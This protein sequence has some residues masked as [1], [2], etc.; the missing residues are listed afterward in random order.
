[1]EQRKP[2]LTLWLFC[3]CFF[4]CSSCCRRPTGDP[5]FLIDAVLIVQ[6]KKKKD[7]AVQNQP[8]EPFL[9]KESQPFAKFPKIVK[10]LKRLKAMLVAVHFFSFLALIM[11]TGANK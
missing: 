10:I 2:A 5:T 8:F 6:G 3:R 7:A 4:C 11:R 9:K 1:M